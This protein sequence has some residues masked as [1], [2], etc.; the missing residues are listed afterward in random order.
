MLKVLNKIGVLLKKTKSG[1]SRISV[2]IPVLEEN[3]EVEI[4]TNSQFMISQELVNNLESI[5]SD[6]RIRRI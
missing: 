1:D 3:K 6:I 2:K 5:N 4:E